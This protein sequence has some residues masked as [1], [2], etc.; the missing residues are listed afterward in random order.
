MVIAE[1]GTAGLGHLAR[2]GA[3]AAALEERGVGVERRCLGAMDAVTH[4]GDSWAPFEVFDDAAAIVVLDSY[5]PPRELVEAVAGANVELVLFDDGIGLVAPPTLVVDPLSASAASEEPGVRRLRG[6][7]YACLGRRY[8]SLPERRLSGELG[9][10]LVTA[11]GA[12]TRAQVEDL[13]S[14]VATAAPDARLAI[15]A[16]VTSLRDQML[17]ADLVV[18]AAGQT[19]LEACACG[20]ACIAMPIADNQRAGAAALARLGCVATA[21][22]IDAVGQEVGRLVVEPAR[23]AKLS[24][25]GREVV[26]GQGAHRV[27]REAQLLAERGG[28]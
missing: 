14:A 9:S 24:E 3:V 5:Q 2:S 16:G 21:A 11:G 27:A 8:W 12:A 1:A 10:I 6:P 20:S 13:V 17:E 18:C 4:E 23:V 15:G 22:D 26:D 25:R 19:M 7:E 28:R